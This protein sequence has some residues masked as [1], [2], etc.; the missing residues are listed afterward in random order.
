MLSKEIRSKFLDYFQERGHQVM[1][2]ASLVSEDNSLLFTSAGMVP[3]KKFFSG[4]VEPEHKRMVSVQ[5]CLRT[6]DIDEVG[7]FNHLTFFEMLGNFSIGDY[8]KEEAIEFAWEFCTEILELNKDRLYVTVHASDTRARETWRSYV[9]ESRIYVLDNNWWGPVGESG[10]CGPCSE[11]YYDT[12]EVGAG[13][14]NCG[15]ECNCGRFLEIWNLVFMQFHSE[16]DNLTPLPRPCVDTGMGLER[17][18]LVLQGQDSVYETDILE[19]IG[20]KVYE[21]MRRNPSEDWNDDQAIRIITE[22]IR[23]VSMLISDRVLPSNVKQGYVVR[24]LI[25]RAVRY[26]KKLHV[27]EPF[28][29][30]LVPTVRE[31]M[32]PYE[33]SQNVENVVML[34][35]RK[36]HTLL[37][38]GEVLVKSL[39]DYYFSSIGTM[40][41]RLRKIVSP[42]EFST[43]VNTGNLPQSVFHYLYDTCGLPSEIVQDILERYGLEKEVGI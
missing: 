30:K 37:E 2:S 20:D 22:H 27:H 39:I 25:R 32:L 26:V 28:L 1:E 4:E 15:P 19:S 5:K 24:R 33:I 16:G 43:F 6:T 12:N 21:L 17:L 14:E 13:L 38:Q 40:P 41:K 29:Y 36:F 31:A 42:E 34:E 23:S 10:P 9:D 7:D 35:E 18:A 11:I 8:F 3:F